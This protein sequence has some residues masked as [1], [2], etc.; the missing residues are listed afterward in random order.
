MAQ[1]IYAIGDIHGD[2]EQLLDIHELI[3]ADHKGADHFVVHVGD[4]VDRRPNS[5]GVLDFIIN[6]HDEGKPWVTLKGNHDRLFQWF[7]ED[8]NRKDP[9]LRSDYTWLH[10]NMGGRD[11]LRSYGIEVVEDYDLKYL[12]AQANE[13]VPTSHREFLSNL[14]ICYETGA[15]F[16][17]H[18]GIRPEVPLRDQSEDDL[19]WIRHDFLNSN[20]RHPKVIIHGH[21]PVDEVTHYGNRINIDT[22]AA[23]GK[24]LSAIVIEDQEVWQLTSAG[25][26]PLHPENGF[27]GRA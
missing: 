3:R 21:T 25:R 17:A 24:K 27:Y 26:L 15:F 23:W 1:T 18:A 12:A 2:L 13:K 7:L 16:F 20:E 5:K 4:L 6:G 11:T 22:G 8:A 9:V 10:P 14:P 19:L